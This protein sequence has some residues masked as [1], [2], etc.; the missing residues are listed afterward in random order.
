MKNADSKYAEKVLEG[1]E[2]VYK[3]GQ[4][5]FWV[6]LALK[7]GPKHMAEI[8]SFIDQATNQAFSVDDMSMYRA[9]R[10]YY[11]AELTDYDSVPGNGP[12]RKIHRLSPIGESVLQRF[13]RRNVV[14]VLY[15]PEIKSLIERSGL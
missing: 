9:L 6:L 8:K 4:L 13:V 14:N 2:D 12:D 3:R 11:E 7:D 15:K 5:T 1:W 10:R